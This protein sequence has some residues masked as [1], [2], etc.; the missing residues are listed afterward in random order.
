MKMSQ[1]SNDTPANAATGIED[2]ALDKESVI[3][4]LGADDDKD[5]E[6]LELEEDKQKGKSKDAG[7]KEE[8]PKEGDEE[9][10]KELTL[11]EELEAELEDPDP[12]KLELVEAPSRKEILAAYPDLF[13]KFPQ[14]EKS[15]YR[16]K[17]YSELL[18][19]IE[20]AKL[21]VEKSSLLDKYEEELIAGSTESIL[22][23]VKDG[24]KEAFAKVVDNYLPNL[25]KVDQHAYY[26][27]IGNVIKH[28]IVSMV[29]DGKEQS[30]EEL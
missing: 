12:D 17:A 7:K 15:M 22:Q 4:F 3:E 18:P 1:Q 9:E 25:F 5:Q 2:T 28:T 14:L 13:K 11:E 16:E 26:H 24:D 23:T 30:N 20:D 27:T 6:A 21:S 10:D 29:R 19:T 8:T